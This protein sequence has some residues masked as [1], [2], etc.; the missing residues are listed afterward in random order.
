MVG[1]EATV[2]GG[3]WR[4]H[5]PAGREQYAQVSVMADPGTEREQCADDA[6][7]RSAPCVE[8]RSRGRAGAAWS[9]SR[10]TVWSTRDHC[11]VMRVGPWPP[12]GVEWPGGAP[13]TAVEDRGAEVA[14]DAVGEVGVQQRRHGLPGVVACVGLQVRRAHSSQSASAVVRQAVLVRARTRAQQ[15]QL[16]AIVW[17]AIRGLVLVHAGRASRKWSSQP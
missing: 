3:R 5:A 15:Q 12:Y 1:A 13:R 8:A 11:H 4:R 10:A 14:E 7:P 16:G 17:E 6:S 9:T 2:S